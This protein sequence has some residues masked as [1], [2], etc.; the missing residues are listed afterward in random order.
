M[1]I[2]PSKKR[3]GQ[4]TLEQPSQKKPHLDTDMATATEERTLDGAESTG[5]GEA[6]EGGKA[7]GTGEDTATEDSIRKPS[8]SKA[9]KSITL[10]EAWKED[11]DVGP[12]L[13]SLV[14]L[15]GEGMLPF[16]PSRELSS[17]L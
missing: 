12:L 2:S 16:I 14:D 15:F 4:G 9:A 6:R 3:P 11:G 1:D 8:R 13:A 17:F 10:S 5:Q 7:Q